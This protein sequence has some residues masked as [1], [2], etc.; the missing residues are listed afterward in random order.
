[1]F[2]AIQPPEP[3]MASVSTGSQ[4]VAYSAGADAAS[5]AVRRADLLR[6]WCGSITSVRLVTGP[7]LVCWP[8][9]WWQRDFEDPATW[10]PPCG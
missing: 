6:S 3:V 8:V 9:D 2:A 1:M 7:E 4:S 5:L 10:D